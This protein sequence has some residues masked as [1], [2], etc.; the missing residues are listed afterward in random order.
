[1]WE[2]HVEVASNGSLRVGHDEVKLLES[3]AKDD[4]EGHHQLDSK[5]CDNWSLSLK[6]IDSKGL[7]SSMAIEK[8]LVAF[9]FIGGQ[10]MFA[11]HHPYQSN[12]IMSLFDFRL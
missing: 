6:V 8:G 4:S 9:D 12:C 11:R 7:F 1:M 5:P 3:P 10:V 2:I